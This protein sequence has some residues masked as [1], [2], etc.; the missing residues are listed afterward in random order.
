[1]TASGVSLILLGA[2]SAKRF[3]SN[4][5]LEQLDGKPVGFYALEGYASLPFARRI[6]VSR[7]DYAPLWERADALGYEV[8][9]NRDPD[10]GIASSIRLGL[11]VWAAGGMQGNGVLFGVSDQPW[12]RARSVERMLEAFRSAP[13]RIVRLEKD[14]REGNP[15]L[16]P[17]SLCAELM[18]LEG[19]V[20]GKRVL[21]RYPGLVLPVEAEEEAE[22][23]DC[24][25]PD[26]LQRK[27]R[28]AVEESF[29]TVSGIEGGSDE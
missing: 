17:V 15:V 20:G 19:D 22:L 16:F 25:A 9:M 12:L 6:Y 24:D 3:G 14:G 7:A 28:G 8:V 13:D 2:G 4:K 23:A 1:M 11:H 29:N 10:R 21:A 5:L 27:P 18:H 26:D